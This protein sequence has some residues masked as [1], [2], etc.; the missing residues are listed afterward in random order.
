[1]SFA[2][3]FLK[4]CATFYTSQKLERRSKAGNGRRDERQ[5]VESLV[6]EVILL[7]RC[8]K[9]KQ[10]ETNSECRYLEGYP[11]RQDDV[12]LPYGS[13][14]HRALSKALNVISNQSR[15]KNSSV[16]AEIG[17]SKMGII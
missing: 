14:V 4:L 7:Q 1:L 13:Y 16:L 3:D 5:V 17:K 2:F 9:I 10:N 15:S 6:P 11:Q 12:C 8:M